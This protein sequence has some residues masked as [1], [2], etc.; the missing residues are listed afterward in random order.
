MELIE[1]SRCN[2]IKAVKSLIKD[3]AEIGIDIDATD[4]CGDTAL[5]WAAYRGYYEITELL[6]DAKA[7]VN[8]QCKNNKTALMWALS[9]SSTSK[10]IIELLLDVGAVVNIHDIIK[11]TP[12][13]RLGYMSEKYHGDVAIKIKMMLNA[14]A[15]MYAKDIHGKTVIDLAKD[16]HN[17]GTVNIFNRHLQDKC[18][19]VLYRDL[20]WQLHNMV[21]SIVDSITL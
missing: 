21:N 8:V 3:C 4:M 18:R 7:N 17:Y 13:M 1:A 16:R 5:M 14:G 12:L 2:D 6:I 15:D 10:S 20:P 11:R 19:H 9:V